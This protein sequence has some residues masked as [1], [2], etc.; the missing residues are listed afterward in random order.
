[1]GVAAADQA[2][3]FD[4][5]V[6]A[7]AGDRRHG[8]GLGLTISRELI[9][10]MGGTIRVSSE[11]GQGACF[12]IEFAVD[13]ESGVREEPEWPTVFA[14]EPGQPEYR[15]LIAEDDRE[16][17]LLLERLL[18]NA[19][20]AV[21]VAQDGAQAVERFREWRPQFVWM[22]L[23]LPVIDGMEA[24]RRIRACEGGSQ[25]KIAAVTA[26]GFVGERSE[27]LAGGLDD[28]LYKPYRPEQIFA[29]MARHL[30]VRYARNQAT[31]TVNGGIAAQLRSEDLAALHADVRRE[32][33]EA[34]ITLEPERI[35]AV[36]K[37]ISHDNAALGSILASYAGESAYTPI[38]RAIDAA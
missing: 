12:R 28:Y 7:G 37:R 10:L 11:P 20:F 17:S 35:S 19:G 14:L 18:Q 2:R 36:I 26:S 33:R 9:K 21:Q 3:I 6:Q 22:D 4:A 24:T 15:V 16:S 13:R 25:V 29:C 27:H 34:L 30:G 8:V 32:L 23:H 5:F 1:M 38:L 31:A